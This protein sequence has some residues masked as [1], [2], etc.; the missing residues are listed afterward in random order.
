MAGT[1]VRRQNQA[2]ICVVLHVTTTTTTT[3]TVLVIISYRG[4]R[5]IRTFR[6]TTDRI[7]DSD[8]IRL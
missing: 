6:S 1:V 8:P 2:A 7:Y 3:T 4:M 5:R